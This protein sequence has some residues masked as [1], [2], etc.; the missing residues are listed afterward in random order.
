MKYIV[1][2]YTSALAD[3]SYWPTDNLNETIAGLK[4]FGFIWIEPR[5]IVKHD[6][7]TEAVLKRCCI[8][9]KAQTRNLQIL[10]NLQTL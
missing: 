6:K 8:G 9:S 5:E 2:A 1:K 7:R 3:P 10:Y 4:K